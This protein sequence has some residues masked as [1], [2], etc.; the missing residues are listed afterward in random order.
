MCQPRPK[1]SHR[2][3]AGEMLILSFAAPAPSS[4]PRTENIRNLVSHSPNLHVLVCGQ[5]PGNLTRQTGQICSSSRQR[6]Q[7]PSSGGGHEETGLGGPALPSEFSRQ[8]ERGDTPRGGRRGAESTEN[9]SSGAAAKSGQIHS[10]HDGDDQVEV[11][12]SGPVTRPSLPSSSSSSSGTVSQGHARA[13]AKDHVSKPRASAKDHVTKPAW[14]DGR[15]SMGGGGR[16]PP[17]SVV[18]VKRIT[19]HEP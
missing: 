16:R 10:S 5:R 2:L 14:D 19:V 17:E 8:G 9:V 7:G 1:L 6:E 11:S 18:K 4:H 12:S 15:R 3:L 13:G